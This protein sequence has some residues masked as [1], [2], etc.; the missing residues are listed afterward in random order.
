MF[1]FSGYWD[2]GSLVLKKRSRQ[3][4]L[5]DDAK[6]CSSTHLLVHR[7]RNS[8]RG[9]LQSHLHDP[10]AASLPDIRESILFE[11]TANLQAR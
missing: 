1:N 3:F 7:N 8:N 10:V 4:R 2:G 9:G 11:N 6:Q 5:S